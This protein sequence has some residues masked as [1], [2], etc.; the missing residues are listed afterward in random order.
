[1]SKKKAKPE[2]QEE[3]ST[4]STEETS[5]Q[6]TMLSL[7]TEAPE[8]VPETEEAVLEEDDEDSEEE[9]DKIPLAKP[10]DQVADRLKP[11]EKKPE[12]V[13]VPETSKSKKVPNGVKALLVVEEDALT[14]QQR[15]D[16]LKGLKTYGTTADI[17]VV[18][19]ISDI[20]LKE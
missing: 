5:N 1:M 3:V 8:Y 17:L 4:P 9:N 12:P 15:A 20:K 19:R 13:K 11:Q 10:W 2:V 14:L 7:P 18:D 6:V 16:F